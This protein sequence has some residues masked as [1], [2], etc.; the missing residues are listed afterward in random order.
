[1][2][3]F[4][5]RAEFDPEAKVWVGSNA[6]LPLTTEAPTIEALKHRASEVASE[7]AVLNGLAEPDEP[8]EIKIVESDLPP[9][10]A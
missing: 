3:R 6:D 10:A 7:I 1:M 9:S 5:L 8:V 4:T 2:K